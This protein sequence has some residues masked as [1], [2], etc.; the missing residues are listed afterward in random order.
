MQDYQV[1]NLATGKF[2]TIRSGCPSVAVQIAYLQD[3]QDRNIPGPSLVW[4]KHTVSYGD[5]ACL[6][7][8]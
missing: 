6:D 8:L 3:N 5:Y 2:V 4:G 7:I 1:L